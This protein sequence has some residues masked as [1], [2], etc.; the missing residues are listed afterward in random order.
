MKHRLF[1]LAAF[2]VLFFTMIAGMFPQHASA[3]SDY[4]YTNGQYDAIQGPSP[5]GQNVTFRKAND[6][7]KWYGFG[8]GV[9][10]DIGTPVNDNHGGFCY[11]A[12]QTNDHR[13]DGG[14][15]GKVYM[16]CGERGHSDRQ[17]QSSITISRTN[18]NPSGGGGAG[19]GGAG[20]DT[21]QCET[22]GFA[23]SWAFCAIING[24][25]GA[26][27]DLYNDFIQP[28]LETKPINVTNPQGDKTHVY[29]IWSNFRVY[30]DIFLV[31]ALLVIV[32]GE[33]V[34]G[35]MIDSYTAKKILPRLAGCR[36]AY[37]S[38]HIYSGFRR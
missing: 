26:M 22:S 35:G 24:L 16:E 21:P 30:G 13:Y 18:P 7:S 36:G 32:F 17:S 20:A 6:P 19:A 37:Q 5:N 11:A 33:S 8:S 25:A 38:L 10:I 15:S 12:I 14:T 27:N 29:D 23:L 4:Y 1:I 3:A 31:I 2:L 28:F 9:Y 34:G